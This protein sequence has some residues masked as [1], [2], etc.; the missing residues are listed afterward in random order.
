MQR[1]LITLLSS[2]A[3][4]VA[5]NATAQSAGLSAEELALLELEEA[6]IP[7][8]PPLEA[9]PFAT[10]TLSYEAGMEAMQANNLNVEIARK[11]LEDAAIIDSQ[12]RS[13][14]VPTIN[15]TGQIVYNSREIQLS[16]GNM[17]APFSP[18]LESTYR[19]DPVLQDYFANNP[20]AI[21]ARML[22]NAP[23]EEMVV[24]PR[25]DFSASATLTQP[26]FTA[27][28][29]PARKL[30][31]IV[32]QQAEAGVEIAAQQSLIAYNQLYFQ[33]VT[34][35]QFIAVA[36]QNVENARIQLDRAQ[37]LFEE[38]AGTKFDVTRAEVQHRAAQRDLANAETSYRLSIEALATLMRVAADFD[39]E[40]PEEIAAPTSLESVLE[41]AMTQRAEFVAS[42]LAIARSDAM[43]QEAKMRKYPTL[44][45]QANASAARV[46][47]FTGKALNWSLALVAS[48]D[49]YDGGAANRDRRSARIEQSRASLQMEQQRDQIRDEIR[50]S[51]I[52][53][54]NQENLIDQAS[55]EMAFAVENYQLTL[56]A[57]NLGAAS[58]L[59]VDMA[60]NQLYQSQLA[61]ADA[62]SS[63][64]AA[65]YNLY[66]IQG[67]SHAILNDTY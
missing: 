49:I 35:R 17:F 14:F 16:M 54:Q 4:L 27:R 3:L 42:E 19:N 46:T 29:F 23:A 55:A 31:R 33:G 24:R 60:Q 1:T 44:V 8:L 65:I 5:S 11:S 7:E 63:K 58:A 66:I 21:D 15:V 10:R 43:A 22:A 30:A 67:T 40:M 37:V 57:R 45:G 48:W 61:Y 38:Q 59:D 39:V 12:A 56:D 53:L 20:D 36:R 32:K 62:L 6:P 51:W 64:M 34:L 50:R 47:V 28:I 13:I 41:V 52:E 25:T 18:Y 9:A 26:L 2:V